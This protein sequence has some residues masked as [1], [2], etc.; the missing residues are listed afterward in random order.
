MRQIDPSISVL[1]IIQMELVSWQIK[2]HWR[3]TTV[4]YPAGKG[5]F[6][7]LCENYTNDPVDQ[8]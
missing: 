2:V 8:A 4:Q 1:D 7:V 5:R 3:L 6:L